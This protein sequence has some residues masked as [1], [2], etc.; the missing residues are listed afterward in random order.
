MLNSLHSREEIIVFFYIDRTM[1]RQN[2]YDMLRVATATPE[3][4]VADPKANCDNLLTLIHQAEKEEVQLL[5]FPELSLTGYTCGDLFFQPALLEAALEALHTLCCQTRDTK[6][7]VIVGLPLAF[8]NCIYDVA[9][10]LHNGTV[11]A[12]VVKNLLASQG[13]KR[14]FGCG[15]TIAAGA[16]HISTQLGNVPIGTDLL[17]RV[18]GVTIGFEIG[19]DGQAPIAPAALAAMGGALIIVNPTAC[20]E[21]VGQYEK[22]R[23]NIVSQSSCLSAAYISASSGVGESTSDLLFSG[24]NLVV[25]AGNVVSESTPFVMQQQMQIADI[26]IAFLQTERQK[27]GS[28]G[29]AYSSKQ[30]RIV[31]TE[32]SH[33]PDVER[34]LY[35][36]IEPNPFV[37]DDDKKIEQRSAE[38][39]NIQ[40]MALASRLAHVHAST[41][42]IGISG[43]LDSTLALLVTVEAFDRLNWSRERIVGITMPGFGTSGRTYTNSLAL[44]KSLGITQREISIVPSVTQHF[45]D[46][47]IDSNIHD[48]TYENSQARERTQILMDAANQMN[49]IVVGTGDLS[50]LALGWCTYNGDH[51]SMYAVNADVPKTLVKSLVTWIAK[52]LCAEETRDILLDIVDTPISPELIPTDSAGD[53]AQK[54]ED[55]VGPYE[56]HDFFLYH[57]IRRGTTP[58]KLYFLARKA[59]GKTYE[60]AILKKWIR[61]FFRRFFMQQFKRSCMPDGPKVGSVGL[62]PRG[63]WQMPSD[64]HARIWLDECDKL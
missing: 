64:A 16:V 11:K 3:V 22:R 60:E 32:T 52:R 51:M 37:L 53:I 5:V 38:I 28:W 47:G 58:S 17:C 46:L 10:V 39:F 12:F 56:L 6:T 25:E 59:W 35:R 43:G 49:G 50:E 13:E 18:D 33:C 20:Y 26:D 48:V 9:A 44:M 21:S 23:D 19:E 31:E 30:Y 63:D 61:N 36:T 2:H 27:Q 14:W 55:L 4:K 8:G 57:V 40:A 24:R 45:A 7:M 41:A 29:L 34:Q 42:I 54:T 62:S 1:N 15:E